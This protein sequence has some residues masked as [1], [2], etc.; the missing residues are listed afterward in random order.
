[1][2]HAQVSFL[3]ATASKPPSP[4]LLSAGSQVARKTRGWLSRPAAALAQPDARQYNQ[5]QLACERAICAEMTQHVLGLLL[6]WLLLSW[7]AEI[8][9]HS[10]ALGHWA[11]RSVM[12][13]N[14][15]WWVVLLPAC[16]ISLCMLHAP[17]AVCEPCAGQRCSTYD[18]EALQMS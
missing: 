15:A 16:E 4:C 11:I 12:E 1:M 13:P 18:L 8:W 9:Q 5:Q 17:L 10:V 14:M 6:A 2:L 7:R 3:T